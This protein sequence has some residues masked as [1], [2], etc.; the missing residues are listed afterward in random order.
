M[1]SP[2][3]LV[4]LAGQPHA[5][6]LPDDLNAGG[7]AGM[8]WIP[9]GS[10]M[11][12]SND[13][14]RPEEGPVHEVVIDGFWMDVH[15]VTVAQFAKFVEATSYR[16]IA[17]RPLEWEELKKQVPAGTPQPPDEVLVPGAVVFHHAQ[18]RVRLDD[19]SGWWQW[20]PGASWKYPEGP[21][22]SVEARLDHP[23]VHIAFE[24]AQAYATWADKQIPTE[25][26]WEF[27]ARGGLNHN[28]FTWG[29]RVPSAQFHPAN[30]WQ[31]E[32]P[33]DDQGL[34]GY[35]GTA[36]VRS[37]P[38]N[39]HGLHDM[40]GNAWEWCS[41]W[42]RPDT[43]ARQLAS[44]R[45]N[46][47]TDPKGPEISWDPSEPK[48]PKRVI[49]G[50]SF[51]CHDSYCTAYRVAARRGAAVDTGLSH[52]GFRCVANSPVEKSDTQQASP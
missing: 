40:A 10:F 12:G 29:D 47:L 33:V 11:M 15:E 16:T 30:I 23:V 27:A 39:A 1:I 35:R 13:L 45:G 19:P 7:P 28:S 43:Y 14:E 48:V 42:Y 3:L 26:Q 21:G 2:L 9:G 20:V 49:R 4:L 37:F 22:S 50:G 36:P 44:T 25:A 38:A 34:D 51:L 32:F 31:G 8:V 52:T 24:D 5:T 17:E 18:D 6:P 41:D 46:P